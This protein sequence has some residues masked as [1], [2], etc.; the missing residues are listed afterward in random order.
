MLIRAIYANELAREI[1]VTRVVNLDR[2]GVV[3]LDRR[4]LSI[5]SGVGWSTCVGADWN[6]NHSYPVYRHQ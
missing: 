6:L 4:D 1:L 3:N 5:M 2:P